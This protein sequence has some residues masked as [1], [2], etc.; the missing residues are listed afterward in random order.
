MD[1]NDGDDPFTSEDL[2]R[3][4]RETAAAAAERG[5]RV[6]VLL[7]PYGAP[8]SAAPRHRRDD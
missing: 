8:Q 5:E 1:P 6:M 2:T 3:I 7:A 4:Y